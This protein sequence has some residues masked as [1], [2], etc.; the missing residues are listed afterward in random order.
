MKRCLATIAMMVVGAF[1][2]GS[3]SACS[4]SYVK[5]Q[6]GDAF[7]SS[8]GGKITRVA[9]RF[10][11]KKGVDPTSNQGE[12]IKPYVVGTSWVD[13]QKALQRSSKGSPHRV[14][15][16]SLSECVRDALNCKHHLNHFGYAKQIAPRP[17]L[18]QA[19]RHG[20]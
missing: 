9:N 7:G 20:G 12:F 8:L 15:N 10:L 5:S 11:T 2:A 19:R 4:A 3:V 13:H 16:K 14:D 17:R 1:L 6:S 18:A